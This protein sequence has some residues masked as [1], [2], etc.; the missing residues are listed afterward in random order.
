MPMIKRQDNPARKMTKNPEDAQ[1]LV[2]ETYAKAFNSFHQFEEGTNLRAWL[3]RILTTTFIN[4]YRKNQRQP[5]ISDEEI[6]VLECFH[7][8]RN[9]GKGDAHRKHPAFCQLFG[10]TSQE[11]VAE[12]WTDLHQVHHGS[13]HSDLLLSYLVTNALAFFPSL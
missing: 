5:L 12:H 1:D 7:Q 9:Y 4:I 11:A 10:F 8:K 6:D 2:Q 3:Y 13:I